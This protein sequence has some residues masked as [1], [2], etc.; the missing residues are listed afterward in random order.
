MD[1]SSYPC[2]NLRPQ[3]PRQVV[4]HVVEDYQLRVRYR[5]SGGTSAANVDHRVVSPVDDQCRHRE[6]PQQGRSVTRRDR[7]ERLAKQPVPARCHLIVC[8][9]RPVT[10]TRLVE[11][12][13]GDPTSRSAATAWSIASSRFVAGGAASFF[14]IS[15]RACP[16]AGSPVVE[17]IEVRDR[18]RSGCSIAI[19]CAICPPIDT[20]AT[21]APSIPSAS[22]SPIPSAA[23][24]DNVYEADDLRY[25]ISECST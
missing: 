12:N 2:G 25:K 23:M 4:S 24:S 7:R 10:H 21:C 19:V 13:P 9:A 11:G 17:L 18:I 6:R 14:H 20:P 5:C 3:V 15:G 22:S 1:E 8:A 16:T